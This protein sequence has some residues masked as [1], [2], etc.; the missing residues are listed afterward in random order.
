MRASI[1]ARA[2]YFPLMYTVKSIL[3][4]L[5]PSLKVTEAAFKKILGVAAF[6]GGGQH[7]TFFKLETSVTVYL[8]DI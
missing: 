3:R 4:R 8:G 2:I 6:G 7:C 5:T 1:L